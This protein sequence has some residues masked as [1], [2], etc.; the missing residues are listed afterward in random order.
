ML[1]NN[2]HLL[3]GYLGGCERIR[4]T[5]LP[6]AYVVH[7]RR[8]L[9]LYCLTLPFAIVEALGW[10]SVAAVLMV[11]YTFFGFEEIGVEI[12]GPFGTTRTTSQCRKS[13]RQSTT[14]CMR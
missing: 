8:A 6:F 10:W 2:V 11:S 12:E 1:E 3:V 5:P 9:V 4:K 7:L 14:T 13:V